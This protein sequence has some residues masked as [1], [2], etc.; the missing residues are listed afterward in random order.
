MQAYFK[1]PWPEEPVPED[2]PRWTYYEVLEHRD[3]VSR[4]IE[5]FANGRLLRHSMDSAP[6]DAR[7]QRDPEYRSLVHGPF[8]A[9]A[10]ENLEPIS[11]Q[12]F[13]DKWSKAED[14]PWPLE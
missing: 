10:A 9:F 5:E 13:E 3:V 14:G 1:E 12:V 11:A 4:R 6:L 7:D 8:L 2:A